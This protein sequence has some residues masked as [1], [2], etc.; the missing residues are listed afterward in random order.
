[1]S[2]GAVNRLPVHGEVL[3]E[4][5]QITVAVRNQMD[6]IRPIEQA[7]LTYRWFPAM[8][9]DGQEFPGGWTFEGMTTTVQGL[10][11]VLKE[12]TPLSAADWAQLGPAL[13]WVWD[14][15]HAMRPRG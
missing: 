14:L 12:G 4:I 2:C 1:M 5:R 11:G 8:D 7:T 6:G 15:V 9:R 3:G 13:G 10:D